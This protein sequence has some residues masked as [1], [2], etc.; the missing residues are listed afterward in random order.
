MSM[1]DISAKASVH[2]KAVASG[3]IFL[4]PETLEKIHGGKIKKGDPLAVGQ[5]AAILAV[6]QTPFLIPFCH[7]IQITSVDVQFTIEK[8]HIEATCTV[9]AVEKTGVEMEALVGVT[10]ALNTIWDMVKYIEKDAQG[11]YPSTRISEV[12]VLSKIKG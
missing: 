8:D 7:P 3:K 2:R 6:K 4:K 1:I 10:N 11:Q 9:Q 5:I 12:G